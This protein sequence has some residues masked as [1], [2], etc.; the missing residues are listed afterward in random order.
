MTITLK[1][2]PPALHRTL[3]KQAKLHKR[4][5]NQET[6]DHLEITLGLKKTDRQA[7]HERIVK[8]RDE[9]KA[10]GFIAMTQDELRA[11]IEEG[12]E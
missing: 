10:E 5:L 2:V 1:N 8:H 12:R 11:A 7:L 6:I 9:M 4:S 3:K